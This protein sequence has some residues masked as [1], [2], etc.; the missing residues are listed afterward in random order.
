MVKYL[1]PIKTE[2]RTREAVGVHQFLRKILINNGRMN[3]AE[4]SLS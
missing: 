2:V 3:A 4:R 1:V